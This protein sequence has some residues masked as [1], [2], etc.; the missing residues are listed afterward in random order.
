MP[1][2]DVLPVTINHRCSADP[3]IARLPMAGPITKNKIQWRAPTG[4]FL[5]VLPG[6]VFEGQTDDFLLRIDQGADNWQPA[7][8][9]KL[10]DANRPFADVHR[11][12]YA[13]DGSACTAADDDNPPEVIIDSTASE[14][15]GEYKAAAATTRAPE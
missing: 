11:Y 5:L 7:I 9:L 14:E 2:P 10:L 15:T 6:G 1:D 3:Q 13:I 12:I 8:P 4:S